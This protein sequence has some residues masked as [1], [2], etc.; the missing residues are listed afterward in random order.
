MLHGDTYT[1]LSRPKSKSDVEYAADDGLPSGF[2]ANRPSFTIGCSVASSAFAGGT[3]AA[4]GAATRT[5]T[6]TRDGF[7]MTIASRFPS[8]RT[9]LDRG[10]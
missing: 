2:D 5:R 3:C 6:S 8:S 4:A 7:I 9:R 1:W 10:G